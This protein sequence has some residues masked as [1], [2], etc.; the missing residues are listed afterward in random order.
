MGGDVT[1]SSIYGTGTTFTATMILE[2]PPKGTKVVIDGESE[3][4]TLANNDFF[5]PDAKV[6]I[7]DDIEINVEIAAELLT[8]A[9]IKADTALSGREALDKCKVENY[10]IIL[11]DHMMPEMDGIETTLE[12]RKLDENYKTIPS[13]ALTAIA[14]AGVKEMFFENGMNDFVPKPIEL[15]ELL[16]AIKRWLPRA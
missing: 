16:A 6:L 7:V 14:V 15:K 8:I 5:A 4:N 3:R 11:M 1:V 2:T 13:I 10:D 12:I 9:G